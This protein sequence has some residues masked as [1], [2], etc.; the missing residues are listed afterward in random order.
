MFFLGDMGIFFVGLVIAATGILGFGVFF[1]DRK[2][3]TNLAFLLL[4]IFTILWSFFNYLG[5]QLVNPT[6]ILWS[7]RIAIFFAVWHAFSI[8][9]LCYV[10]PKMTIEF[11]RWYTRFLFPLAFAASILSLTPFVFSEVGSLDTFGRISKIING[12]LIPFFGVSVLFFNGGG[13]YLL[14][15]KT[16]RAKD[17][18]RRQFFLVLLG[19]LITIGFIIIF[20]FIFP[21]FLNNPYFVQYGA[22]FI[23]PFISFTSYA[24]IKH[25]LLDLKVVSTEVLT[26]ILSSVLLFQI[27]TA[28]SLISFFYQIGIF[29]SVLLFGILLI[30]SVRNQVKQREDVTHLAHLLEKANLRLQEIDRQK[31]EFLS[32][33]SH[34]LRTPLSIIKGYIELIEDGAYGKPAKEMKRVLHVMDVSNERLVTLID[35]FLDITRIEQGRTKFSFAQSDM[36]ALTDGVVKEL[37]DR[38]KKKGLML[39]WTPTVDTLLVSMDEEKIRHVIFN[40][41]DNAIKYTEKGSVT[42]MLGKEQDGVSVK[43]HDSGIGFGKKDQANFYQ[44]FYRGENVKGTNVNGTGLGL[45]VCRKFIEGHGGRV[46]ATS[47]GI[48]KGS[49]FGFLIPEKNR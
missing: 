26:F 14:F 28:K 48:G 6:H 19:L 22:I 47:D 1:N 5:Y 16:I 49:E 34:Q 15:K 18:Q 37:T 44:K 24:I 36:K 41:V 32:I 30:K 31:T 46:W 8:F 39:V 13:L 40:F 21:A 11:P 29:F 17:I 4:C 45:Y 33:A 43:V 2:S 27:V 12:P 9:H 23:F 20:N 42:V 25:K 7:F 38:G 10:L 3:Q 35:E